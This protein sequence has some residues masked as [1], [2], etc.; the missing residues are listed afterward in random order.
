MDGKGENIC[1]KVNYADGDING[2][3]NES[4]TIQKP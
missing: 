1:Q 3:F 4:F 2:G